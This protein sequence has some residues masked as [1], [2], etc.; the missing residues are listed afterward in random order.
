MTGDR[1]LR[2]RIV[3]LLEAE[4]AGVVV[5]KKMLAE[6]DSERETTLLKTILDGE[7]D[8]CRALGKAIVDLGLTGSDRIGDFVGKVM[9]L[10]DKTDRLKLLIKGQEWVV[11]KLD[12]VLEND[13]PRRDNE[14][15][16]R[17]RQDHVINIDK[18]KKFL[19]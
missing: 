15:L 9:H 4:R 2:E 17:I 8:G 19:G 1:E 14:A 13:L 11:R 10:Q 7:K 3:A 12:D 5:A 18:C 6:S 16:E